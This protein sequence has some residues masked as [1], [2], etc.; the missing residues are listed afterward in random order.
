MRSRSSRRR[1]TRPRRCPSICTAPPGRTSSAANPGRPPRFAAAAVIGLLVVAAGLRL[2][3]IN[4]GL[5]A[6]Y[7]PDE[8]V[9]VGRAMGIFH[10]ILDPHFADWPHLYF[11]VAAAWLAPLRLVGLV[12]DQASAY[13]G[14]RILDALLGSVTV[15]LVFEFG[16]RAYG[17]LAGF[18]G[19]S[20][21]AVAFLHVRDSHFGTLDTP[22]TLAC[23]PALHTAY[24]TIPPPRFRPLL[25]HA[26]TLR[27]R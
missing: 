13:L 1:N 17:W 3:G 21:L 14:V 25:L 23:V 15:L 24:I 2:W 7:R 6:L 26:V 11:Y 12:Q 5:P 18:F 27:A 19:A 9:T 10:G 8:D 4:F 20:P 16:R 22:L